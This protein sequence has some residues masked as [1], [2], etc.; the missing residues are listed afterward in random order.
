MLIFAVWLFRHPSSVHDNGRLGIGAALM[1]SSVSVLCHVFGGQPEPADGA[2]A[3]AHGG[4]VIG[5]MLAWP[6]ASIGAAW[7]AVILA[8][9]LLVLSLFIITKTPPNR[10]G[11]RL[12]ELY[13]YLFGAE[14]PERAAEGGRDR[15]HHDRSA[16]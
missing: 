6:F 2:G 12:R 13:A 15:R 7:F 16:R 10:I 8:S 5:W 14:L 9:G 4:G 3:L 1:L 11:D